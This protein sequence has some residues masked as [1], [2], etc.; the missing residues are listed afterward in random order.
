MSFIA[1]Q[2]SAETLR[3]QTHL[4]NYN[5]FQNVK[6]SSC[7]KLG[8][9]YLFCFENDAVALLEIMIQK[10]LEIHSQTNIVHSF[11]NYLKTFS[12]STLKRI[13]A[14][15]DIH[16]KC[17]IGIKTNIYIKLK[18]IIYE[19]NNILLPCL[20]PMWDLTFRDPPM[21]FGPENTFPH[22]NVPAYSLNLYYK[23]PTIIF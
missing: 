1:Y 3:Q 14:Y 11:M 22:N 17:L 20:L 8:H 18:D 15:L 13:S 10:F 2:L 4:G 12:T 21:L 7:R 19:R 23:S 6:C 16:S 9:N 5:I